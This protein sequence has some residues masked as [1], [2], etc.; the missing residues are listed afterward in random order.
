MCA[1]SPASSLD[2]EEGWGGEEAGERGE[3][4]IEVVRF[5]DSVVFRSFPGGARGSPARARAREC[6]VQLVSATGVV[7]ERGRGRWSK[8][9]RRGGA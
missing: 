2:I 8:R 9:K 3:R 1:S 5:K 4:L 7:E 6:F